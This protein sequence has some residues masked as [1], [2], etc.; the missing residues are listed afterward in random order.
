MTGP[1]LTNAKTFG[2]LFEERLQRNQKIQIKR[3]QIHAI[4]IHYEPYL[5]E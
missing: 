5:F 4:D 1:E 2:R 3:G